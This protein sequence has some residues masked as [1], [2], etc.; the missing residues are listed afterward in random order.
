MEGCVGAIDGYF[1]WIQTPTKKEVGN[2]I[3]YYSGHYE[4]HGVNC[5]ACVRSDL[6]FMYFG[7]VAPGS[8]NDNISYPLAAGLKTVVEDLP[9]GMYCVADAAYTLQEN[10]LIPFTGADRVD[11][12]HDSFNFYLSQL[13]VVSSVHLIE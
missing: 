10:L 1:Q 8:T 2:V 3:A 5:Q 9:T 13:R 11:A 6:R 4:S 12:A 7:V